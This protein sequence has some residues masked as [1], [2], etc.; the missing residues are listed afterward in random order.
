MYVTLLGTEEHL[1]RSEPVS[2]YTQPPVMQSTQ[3]CDIE[4]PEK[5]YKA[6]VNEYCQKN[7]QP[8][9]EYETE[10]SDNAT[11]FVSV[12]TICGKEYQSKPCGSKKKAEQNVAGIAALDIGL[13]ERE[14]REG[15]LN[16]RGSFLGDRF[17][18]RRATVPESEFFY[19]VCKSL[20][21]LLYSLLTHIDYSGRYIFHLYIYI[22]HVLT[23]MGLCPYDSYVTML[24]EEEHLD[25]SEAVS[26]HTPPPIMQARELAE[27]NYKAMIN[28]YCQKNYLPLPKYATD[29]GGGG[30]V[31]T[32]TLTDYSGVTKHLQGNGYPNKKSAEQSAAKQACI[33]CGLEDRPT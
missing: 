2:H 18:D 5:N 27:K 13:V 8:L 10:Y 29:V 19:S 16:S 22:I 4:L 20:R 33:S 1:D 30:F 9:P 25:R 3:A 15:P 12:L 23:M 26:H 21:S 7:Y 32:V 17:P 14:G 31:S 6:M 24:G 28:E 11:G